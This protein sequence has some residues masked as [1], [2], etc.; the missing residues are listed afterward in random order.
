MLVRRYGSQ[1]QGVDTNFD[2]NAITEIAFRRNSAFQMPADD[3]FAS[4]TR[5]GEHLVAAK[6]DAPVQR[7]AQRMIIQQ[8]LDQI[9]ALEAGLGENEVLLFE[10]EPAKDFP[11][12]HEKQEGV[13]VGGQNRLVFHRHV[14]PPL[15]FGRY[16][17]AESPASG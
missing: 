9:A 3:F 17:R 8:L 5:A 4:Y 12:E 16:R 15:R 2:P 11:R 6:S 14:D 13:I 1:V 7:D 10:N